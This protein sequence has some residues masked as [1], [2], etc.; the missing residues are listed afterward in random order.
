M[1]YC[2]DDDTD[3]N[4]K[5]KKNYGYVFIKGFKWTNSVRCSVKNFHNI[6]FYLIFYSFNELMRK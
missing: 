4:S 5:L 3:D 6:F 2:T 1:K